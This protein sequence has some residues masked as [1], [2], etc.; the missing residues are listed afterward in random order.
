MLVPLTTIVRERERQRRQEEPYGLV[1]DRQGWAN[2]HELMAESHTSSATPSLSSQSKFDGP[3]GYSMTPW[4]MQQIF[5]RLNPRYLFRHGRDFRNDD[6]QNKRQAALEAGVIYGTRTYD[7]GTPTP[8]VKSPTSATFSDATISEPPRVSMRRGATI[9]RILQAS[10]SVLRT[11]LPSTSTRQKHEPV[12]ARTHIEMATD[13]SNPSLVLADRDAL[14]I[15]MPQSVHT[16]NTHVAD[17]TST[18]TETETETR[19]RFSFDSSTNGSLLRNNSA[20]SKATEISTLD[21]PMSVGLDKLEDEPNDEI[22]V[23]F[24]AKFYSSAELADITAF[25]FSDGAYDDGFDDML[26]DEVNAYTTEDGFIS[27]DDS[28]PDRPISHASLTPISEHADEDG[29]P[30]ASPVLSSPKSGQSR[31]VVAYV[32]GRRG[33]VVERRMRTGEWGYHKAPDGNVQVCAEVEEEL[34]ATES[35]ERR[36]I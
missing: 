5:R 24:P 7:W 10:K 25:D 23:P 35:L 16:T 26:I 20:A 31:Q 19:R 1:P 36:A 33:W 18:E 9:K 34:V 14:G 6:T 29:T 22:A 32:R 30:A 2:Q 4:S 13:F 17:T 27:P 28:D 21:A 3:R 15:I 8:S 11:K 12:R